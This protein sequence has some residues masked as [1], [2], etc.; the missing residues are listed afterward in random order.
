MQIGFTL[1]I[2]PVFALYTPTFLLSISI[3]LPSP[4]FIS[5]IS[6]FGILNLLISIDLLA[7]FNIFP[8]STLF[9]IGSTLLALNKSSYSFSFPN[10]LSAIMFAATFDDVIPHLLNP[11]ATYTL[12]IV[13]EK[14]PIYGILSRLIQ[15]SADHLYNTSASG[16]IFLTA[17]SSLVY[18]FF[19]S[20]VPVL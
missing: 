12:G 15:S 7:S 16:Y 4:I 1:K 5:S 18:P 20:S 2:S 14:S 13:T 10:I 19:N 3:I 9:F 17:V 11:V 6:S 8:T